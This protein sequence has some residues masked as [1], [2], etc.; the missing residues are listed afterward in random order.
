MPLVDRD[1]G[2]VESSDE[3][4][5]EIEYILTLTG[6]Q[7]LFEIRPEKLKDG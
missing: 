7:D 5:D 1:V 3:L 2:R 4:S 6:R